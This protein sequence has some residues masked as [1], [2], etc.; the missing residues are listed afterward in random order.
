LVTLLVLFFL[1]HL[2]AHFPPCKG[3]IHHRSVQLLLV[4]FL[5][6]L[7]GVKVCSTTPSFVFEL[8][9]ESGNL[10]ILTFPFL[11]SFIDLLFLLHQVDLYVLQRQDILFV[12]L[13]H[14]KEYLSRVILGSLW[15]VV[16]LLVPVIGVCGDLDLPR[17]MSRR[18]LRHL[19][20]NHIFIK[21]L[22]LLQLVLEPS[23]CFW[24][25]RTSLSSDESWFLVFILRN[26]FI[27]IILCLGGIRRERPHLLTMIQNIG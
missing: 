24:L 21:E 16:S 23:L 11:S 1:T 9:L 12:L 25:D 19:I 14:S 22:N 7:R 2:V 4:Q 20:H 26:R 6:L 8:L 17:D 13:L 27:I 18:Y 10:I 5:N 3:I 15:N